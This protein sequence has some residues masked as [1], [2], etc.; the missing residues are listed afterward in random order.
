MIYLNKSYYQ[1]TL[2]CYLMSE[3]DFE[4]S[5]QQRVNQHGEV[6]GTGYLVQRTPTRIYLRKG[7]PSGMAQRIME[8][9]RVG[10]EKR[11]GTKK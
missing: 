8:Y 5:Y 7:K 9:A 3:E 10:M 11:N 1:V 4:I 6:I 2:Q